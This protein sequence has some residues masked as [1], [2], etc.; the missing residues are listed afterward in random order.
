MAN[1]DFRWATGLVSAATLNGS[2]TYL[3]ENTTLQSDQGAAKPWLPP[4]D[5]STFPV[6]ARIEVYLDGSVIEDGYVEFE[7]H[8]E[9]LTE[10]QLDYIVDTFFGSGIWSKNMTVKTFLPDATYTVYQVHAHRPVPNRDFEA[11]DN[12]YRNVFLRFKRGVAV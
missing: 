8:W 6:S 3:V 12:G 11:G 10:G 2:D 4:D 5:R 9:Y 1:S 7:W